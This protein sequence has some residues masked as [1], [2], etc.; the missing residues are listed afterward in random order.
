V[1]GSSQADHGGSPRTS[2]TAVSANQGA[3]QQSW[4][5]ISEADLLS[6]LRQAHEGADPDL[7]L[8]EHYANADHEEIK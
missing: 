8:A 3:C 2:G 1:A 6:L 4:H 7:L 5:V